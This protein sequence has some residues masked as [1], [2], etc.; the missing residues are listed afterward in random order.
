MRVF[1]WLATSSLPKKFQEERS[2]PRLRD[3]PVSIPMPSKITEAITTYK[4]GTPAGISAHAT[5]P[6]KMAKP[7]LL[8]RLQKT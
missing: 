8:N 6:R 4:V 5:P 7:N 3:K 1:C 2:L